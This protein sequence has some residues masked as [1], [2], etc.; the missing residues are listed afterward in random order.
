MCQEE[1]EPNIAKRLFHDIMANSKGCHTAETLLPLLGPDPKAWVYEGNHRIIISKTP[2]TCCC[3]HEIKEVIE[4]RRK[5]PLVDPAF[6]GGPIEGLFDEDSWYIGMDCL[7]DVTIAL[8]SAGVSDL[9]QDLYLILHGLRKTYNGAYKEILV[10]P[11]T[12]T[13]EGDHMKSISCKINLAFVSLQ[14]KLIEDW[15]K[16]Q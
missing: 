14:L 3:G 7:R 4:I 10:E 11:V 6:C 1:K 2:I 9:A 15:K 16:K 12:V 13:Y 8:D 5:P